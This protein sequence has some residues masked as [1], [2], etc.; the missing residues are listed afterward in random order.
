MLHQWFISLIPTMPRLQWWSIA[1]AD[2]G[3]VITGGPREVGALGVDEV[4][5][6]TTSD[7]SP[8]SR[9]SRAEI[10]DAMVGEPIKSRPMRSSLVTT[11]VSPAPS[12]RAVS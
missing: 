6:R 9:Q 3:V 11:C 4:G 8:L 10:G 7:L 12:D 5:K 2:P 1:A